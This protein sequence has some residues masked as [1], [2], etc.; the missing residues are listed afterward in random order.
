MKKTAFI[1]IFI[2]LLCPVVVGAEDYA[3]LVGIPGIDGSSD[4][5]GFINSLYTLSISIAALLAVIKIVIAGVKWML[6]DI[7]TSKSE[8]KKDIE[9]ALIGLLIILAAV[10]ILKEINPNLVKVNLT[11]PVPPSSG[12]SSGSS[13]N[14]PSSN[15]STQLLY[16]T[17]RI[18]ICTRLDTSQSC[19]KSQI[20]AAKES[21]KGTFTIDPQRPS[22]GLC[23]TPRTNSN[24]EEGDVINF[25]DVP[26]A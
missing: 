14:S 17:E 15:S 3:P 21:C 5:N 20:D 19:F 1:T 22:S 26:A 6:T 16:D 11:F 24:Y 25:S 13:Q 7:V 2:I 23:T 8:A 18:D 12:N 9:G 10:L 4:F